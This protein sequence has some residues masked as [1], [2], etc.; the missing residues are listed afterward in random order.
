MKKHE[1]VGMTENALSICPYHSPM[2]PNTGT[3]IFNTHKIHQLT[4]SCSTIP[5]DPRQCDNFD[6]NN[7]LEYGMHED[8]DYYSNCKLRER[9]MGLFLAD[10]N[11]RGD[12]A[13]YTRQ[14]QNGN[15]RGYECPEERDYYPYWHPTPWRV[16]RCSA[17]EGYTIIIYVFSLFVQ[18]IVIFTTDVSRC[19]YYQRESENVKSRYVCILPTDYINRQNSNNGRNDIIPITQEDCE[20]CAVCVC[21]HPLV[22]V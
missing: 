2:H 20:V 8:F 4:P 5:E 16:R 1:H 11:L 9:N 12:T 19:P 18:D 17:L 10:R 7:D 15:R 21:V 6:C 14:N 13:K 22:R 3:H